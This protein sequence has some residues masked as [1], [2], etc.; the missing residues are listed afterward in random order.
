MN[1]NPRTVI[2]TKIR[3]AIEENKCICHL[4]ENSS[5]RIIW[6]TSKFYS[7]TTQKLPVLEFTYSVTLWTFKN[8]ANNFEN[9]IKKEKWWEKYNS[10]FYVIKKT[11]YT[12]A[13]HIASHS[14][15]AI[16]RSSPDGYRRRACSPRKRELS[17]PFSNG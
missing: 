7:G 10:Q 1:N 9:S 8:T 5:W 11:V 2:Q 3:G 13:G 14:L 17:G 15:H 16:Q 4:K 12:C 6:N